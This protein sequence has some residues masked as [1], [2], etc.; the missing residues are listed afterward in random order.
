[1]ANTGFRG[2]ARATVAAAGALFG[3]AETKAVLAGWAEVGVE[4]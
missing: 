3:D 1:M 4:V 2:F